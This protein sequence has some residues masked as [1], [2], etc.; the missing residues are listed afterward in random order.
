LRV[1]TISFDLSI[2]RHDTPLV[3]S[4]L[5]IANT[6]RSYSSRAK[7]R[8]DPMGS[9]PMWV[10]LLIVRGL[11]CSRFI[12]KCCDWPVGHARLL[13]RPGLGIREP[14]FT[15]SRSHMTMTS[16]YVYNPEGVTRRRRSVEYTKHLRFFKACRSLAAR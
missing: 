3:S 15:R 11:A 9:R 6:F 2:S 5:E 16:G 14:A 13:E 12:E 4:C 8:I 1:E 10:K 7:H